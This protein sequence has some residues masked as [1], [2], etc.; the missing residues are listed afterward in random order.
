MLIYIINI[1]ITYLNTLNIKS[2]T[3]YSAWITYSFIGILLSVC[4]TI[5]ITYILYIYKYKYEKVVCL[6]TWFW[7]AR[8]TED[9][10]PESTK[11]IR[12]AR[13]KRV[14]PKEW[15]GNIGNVCT[16]M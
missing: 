9:G 16:M 1:L 12:N 8:C 6:V 14:R 7:E 5:Y 13:E 3:M 4:L 2:E 15:L 11:P 10:K